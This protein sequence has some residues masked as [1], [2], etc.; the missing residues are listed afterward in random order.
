MKRIVSVFLVFTFALSLGSSTL[1]ARSTTAGQAGEAVARWLRADAK[2]LGA[3][4]GDEV[5]D[6]TPY[7]DQTGAV[8]YY[9]VA[10]EPAGFVVVSADDRIEPIIAYSEHGA[11]DPSPENPLGS[12]VSRDLS[13][14]IAA[15]RR[16][17]EGAEKSPENV[18]KQR[19]WRTLTQSSAGAISLQIADPISDIRIAPL[20][21]SRWSQSSVCGATCYNYYTPN[22]YPC[23]C[24]ATAIAQIMLYHRHPVDSIGIRG[25]TIEVDGVEEYAAT[26]GGDGA[27]GPY[28]WDYMLDD[29]WGN[30]A[31]LTSQHRQAIGALCYDVGIAANMS[32]E[33]SGSAAYYGP[34]AKA[35]V[36]TFD[37]GD[38]Q[39]RAVSEVG[40]HLWDMINA[41]LDARLPVAL[42]I[43]ND[44]SG[45]AVIADGYGYIGTT[46]YHHINFGWAGSSDAWYNLPDFGN[47]PS[48]DTIDTCTYNIY[49]DGAGQIIS[50]RVIDAAG[51]PVTNAIVSAQRAEVRAGGLFTTT[52]DEKGIYAISRI[53]ADSTYTLTASDEVL[54][55]EPLV[56]NVRGNNKWGVDLR[57]E[58]VSGVL[59]GVV[60]VDQEAVGGANN[61]T[62]WADA[63]V[64]LQDA[65][66]AAAWS[67]DV[68]Q[69]W[70][71]N[72]T[73]L[74]DRGTGDR[75]LSFVIPD[76][77]AVYGGFAG[78]EADLGERE[79]MV[80]RTVLCGDLRA[81]DAGF[82]NC[83]DNSI[84][85]LIADGVGDQTV[86]DGFT[87]T[88]GNADGIGVDGTTHGGGLFASE[89]MLS[90]A[91]CT[92][93]GN[94]AS[95]QGGGVFLAGGSSV[96][97]A[98]CRFEG[99][100]A[101]SGGGLAQ[102]EASSTMVG[103][104]FAGNL[105]VSTSTA[106]GGA[107]YA[108]DCPLVI[109]A[110]CTLVDNIAVRGGALA[111][112]NSTTTMA[113]SIVWGNQADAGPEVDMTAS[114]TVIV[115]YC[116]VEGGASSVE[117]EDGCIVQWGQGN[118]DADPLFVDPT[119]QDWH[120]LLGSPCI[121]A[122]D[123]DAS[124]EAT[125]YDMDGQQR[126]MDGRI[127]IGA[128]ENSAGDS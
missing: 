24:V 126:I 107:V 46:L 94:A 87:I 73:Y 77:V 26:R 41:N 10:L 121:D 52:S 90:I 12:L 89:A 65:L 38:A 40:E 71:A 43:V 21:Q 25:F 29:P 15:A 44:E 34:I 97:V 23:G 84:H 45:H 109:A 93:A 6:I 47:Y 83:T 58:A 61:G 11:F 82:R 50:G 3:V 120:I 48:Y 124:M 100:R 63:F 78:G 119:K 118:I 116:N 117:I 128:D 13:A 17:S 57:S 64:D 74:P 4:L 96:H 67:E 54:Q 56:V 30:C 53:P 7:A 9:V 69:V 59:M 127:D 79:A 18:A 88:G 42:G 106:L 68:N 16:S 111:V 99:N 114:A 35:L 108:R 62:S 2:P 76:G 66:A 81:N 32:Y 103:C 70:V 51:R 110:N 37:Y 122:G 86:L 60:F 102:V 19:R 80:N 112:E 14:R 113:S 31:Q 39:T 92:F 85:V 115:S 36:S 125:P 104:V 123:P 27:G 95:D 105:A 55:W 28:R 72:G 49:P 20:I 91:N 5:D 75:S 33:A 101:A 98:N 22:H 8:A 1:W